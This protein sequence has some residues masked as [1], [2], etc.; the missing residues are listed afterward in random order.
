MGEDFRA[1]VNGKEAWTTATFRADAVTKEGASQSLQGRWTAV[2]EKRGND[3]LI[4]HEHT[5][6]PLPAPSK[7]E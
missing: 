3:W 7:S 1:H 6:V 4:V 5:S 2:W